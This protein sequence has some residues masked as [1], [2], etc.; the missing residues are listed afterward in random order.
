MYAGNKNE[1]GIKVKKDPVILGK[2]MVLVCLNIKSHDDVIY[3]ATMENQN[4]NEPYYSK[5]N[6]GDE[7]YYR[8]T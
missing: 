6:F 8:D 5:E 1:G 3:A 7:W 4:H 2:I